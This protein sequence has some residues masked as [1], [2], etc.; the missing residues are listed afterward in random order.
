ML[1]KYKAILIKINQHVQEK[2]LN[3]TM[4]KVSNSHEICASTLPW[5]I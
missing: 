1:I 5:E 4:E 2:T 3:K